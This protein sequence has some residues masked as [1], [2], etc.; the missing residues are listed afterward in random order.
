MLSVKHVI[1]HGNEVIYAGTHVRWH[2]QAAA[3]DPQETALE[4]MDRDVVVVTLRAC[5]TAYVMNDGGS[6]VGAYRLP[7]PSPYGVLQAA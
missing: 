2:E 1:D 5:G 4:V 3:D 6:T 7:P